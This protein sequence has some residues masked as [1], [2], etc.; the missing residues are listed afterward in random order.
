MRPQAPALGPD[1]AQLGPGSPQV[2]VI[3]EHQGPETLDAFIG[4][5]ME[6]WGT[7]VALVTVLSR[8]V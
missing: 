2:N 5:G 1:L 6:R 8:V 4:G 7:E 3:W